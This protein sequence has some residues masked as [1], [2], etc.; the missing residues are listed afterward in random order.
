MRIKLAD[1]QLPQYSKCEEIFNM[2]SHIV[3]GALGIVVLVLCVIVAAKHT[4]NYGITSSIVYGITMIMLY[5]MSSIY[6]GLAPGT[7]KKVFQVLDHCAIYFL[8][9]GTY[10]PVALSAI[11]EINPALGWSLFSIEWALAALAVT[12]T[13][14][15]IKQYNVFSM[16]CYISMGWIVIFIYKQAVAALT[17]NGFIL[18]LVGGIIY[19]IG[20]VLYGLGVKTKYMH[21]AFHIFVLFGSLFHFFAIILYAL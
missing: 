15:D 20:A 12:L 13:A 3:G 19:T 2:A 4:N 9:A 6:H 17:M 14:I 18:L 8:I 11:R 10:T 5:C 1:R 16:V 7:A 21:N